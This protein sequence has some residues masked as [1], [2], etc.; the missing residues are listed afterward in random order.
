MDEIIRIP[1][2]RIAVL[3]GTNGVTRKTIAK[4]TKI[5]IN[6]DSSNGEVTLIGEGEN[7]FKARDVVHAIGRG[8]SP[9][10]AFTL[11]EDNY[12]LKIVEIRDFTGKNRSAQ[13]AKRGR[14]IGREGEARR[15]IEKKTGAL[16]SVY[17][18]TVAIIAKPDTIEEA[19]DVVEMLLQGATHETMEH[20]LEEKHDR[21][22]L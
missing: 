20:F 8:F 21:F 17:G 16:I 18:K 7:F 15:E 13:E 19:T 11:L 14:V 9:K 12:L 4:R 1:D 2:E 22:E 3:I 10:R 6:I 5:K